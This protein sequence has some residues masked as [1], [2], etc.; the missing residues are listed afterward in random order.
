MRNLVYILVLANL[1]YFAWHQYSP[2]E[3]PGEVKSAPLAPG[4]EPL[5]LLAERRSAE[6]PVLAAAEKADEVQ[7]PIA[8]V[9]AETEAIEDALAELGE[10]DYSEEEVRLMR[11]K[12]ISEMGH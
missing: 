3:K 10:E 1:A 7:Q 6:P 8:A 9:E 2:I 11:I 4:I 12:F 5:V